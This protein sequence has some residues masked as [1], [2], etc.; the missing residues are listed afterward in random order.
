MWE[1]EELNW[2]GCQGR[3]RHRLLSFGRLLHANQ[4]AHHEG[5]HYRD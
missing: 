2:Q 5:S 3:D 4:E 1:M